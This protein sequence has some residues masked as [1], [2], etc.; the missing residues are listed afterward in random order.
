MAPI[1]RSTLEDIYGPLAVGDE[2]FEAALNRSLNPRGPRMLYD[3][4]GG[5]GLAAQHHLLDIGSRDAKYACELA[6]R[7]GCSALAVDP[8]SYHLEKAQQ[9]IA[10]EGLSDR[11]TAAV[12]TI[13]AIPAPD[14]TF[15]FVW[16]RD[17]LPHVAD[18]DAAFREVARVTKPGGKM[19]IYSTVRTEWLDAA[20][21]ERVFGALAVF[22]T[23]MDAENLEAAWRRAGFRTIH[24][25]VIGSEWRERWEEDGTHTTS[26]Q[27]LRIARMLRDRERLEAELGEKEYAIELADCHWGVYQML[28][29]LRPMVFV[30]TREGH[31]ANNAGNS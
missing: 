4:I 25:E 19:V 30:L 26:K 12:G 3:V 8:L 6:K 22:F 23:S 18:L 17:M 28:G 10:E 7:F 16:A 21:A 29:K 11:V 20:E 13:E 31:D 9:R 2:A 14:Q 24:S 15:D 27:L 5:Q 1:Q